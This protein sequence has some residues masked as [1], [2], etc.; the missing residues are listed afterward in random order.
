MR[1]SWEKLHSVSLHVIVAG[2][3]DNVDGMKDGLS[4]KIFTKQ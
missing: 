2:L 3:L 1:M 4:S